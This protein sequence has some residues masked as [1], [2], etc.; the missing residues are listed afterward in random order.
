MIKYLIIWLAI[1]LPTA[2]IFGKAIKFGRDN[3]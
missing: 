3:D 2:I 1:G